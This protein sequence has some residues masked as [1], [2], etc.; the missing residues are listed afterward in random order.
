MLWCIQYTYNNIWIDN[1]DLGHIIFAHWFVNSWI[2]WPL[3]NPWTNPESQ[4][5]WV[6]SLNPNWPI[7]LRNPSRTCLVFLNVSCIKPYELFSLS[8]SLSLSKKSCGM[9]IC[10]IYIWFQPLNEIVI[11]LCLNF[12]KLSLLTPFVHIKIWLTR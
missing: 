6:I 1:L 7:V 9:G 10:S 3:L 2:S 8:L 5:C 4:T 11:F 12:M